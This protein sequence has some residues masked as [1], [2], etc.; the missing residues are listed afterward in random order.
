MAQEPPKKR[1]RAKGNV[2][3]QN[4]GINLSSQQNNLKLIGMLSENRSSCSDR[5][6]NRSNRKN[7]SNNCNNNS[8]NN[9][10]CN[11]DMDDVNIRSVNRLN[12]SIN[13]DD[14][15]LCN[16]NNNDNENDNDFMLHPIATTET[17]KYV[18]KNLPMQ[19]IGKLP[20]IA[21]VATKDLYETVAALVDEVCNTLILGL[22]SKHLLVL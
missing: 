22:S 6:R 15:L 21:Q 2:K 20:D 13:I 19:Y 14:M 5:H 9:N 11:D 8:N 1:Q 10:N 7:H 16:N 3:Q 12:D 18:K 17:G 4:F